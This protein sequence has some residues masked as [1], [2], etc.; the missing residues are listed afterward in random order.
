MNL[1]AVS[2]GPAGDAEN[3]SFD[4]EERDASIEHDINA[5]NLPVWIPDLPALSDRNHSLFNATG[6][7]E[8]VL[9]CS[10]LRRLKHRLDVLAMKLAADDAN[11]SAHQPTP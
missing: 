2:F 5:W 1:G 8:F 9:G 4:L 11:A 10:L 6:E 7:L 3:F